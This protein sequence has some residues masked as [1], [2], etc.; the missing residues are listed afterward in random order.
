MLF[1]A[2]ILAIAVALA[3]FA[4]AEWRGF[5]LLICV[6]IVASI[7][8]GNAGISGVWFPFFHSLQAIIFMAFFLKIQNV[9]APDYVQSLGL[10]VAIDLLAFGEYFV[11]LDVFYPV[12]PYMLMPVAIYQLWLSWRGGRNGGSRV[13]VD[14]SFIRDFRRVRDR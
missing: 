1:S 2:L 7:A 9:Y 14:F 4:K 6:E 13:A 10:V 3:L 5:S 12:R 8:I 11:G